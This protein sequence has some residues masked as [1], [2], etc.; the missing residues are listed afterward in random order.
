MNRNGFSIDKE[1]AVAGAENIGLNLA[2]AG[3]GN[4]ML[5]F[6]IDFAIQS[7]FSLGLLVAVLFAGLSLGSETFTSVAL[8]VTLLA[9]FVIQWGYFII[10]E[11]IWH[12][13]TPGKRLMR[14]KVVREDGRPVGFMVSLLRN[15]M[16]AVDM[17]PTGYA[18]GI[19]SIFING[20][21]K[22]LGDLVAGTIVVKAP[23][24]AFPVP[25][26][27]TL[28]CS[29]LSG[30]V[31]WQLEMSAHHLSVAE[32]ELLREYLERRNALDPVS[33]ERLGREL[34]AR[35]A[36]CFGLE[37]PAEAERFLEYLGAIY[38]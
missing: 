11:L 5:A 32:I 37:P 10:F 24:T 34:S 27:N 6:L 25:P 36:R 22:R 26:V 9:I 12:G 38:F 4:R 15:I 31:P 21:E 16:R 17:L 18:T 29:G 33:R 13:Q 28:P 23:R 20:K 35:L 1:I 3:L 19:I 2:L 14:I 30:P 7:V 8:G